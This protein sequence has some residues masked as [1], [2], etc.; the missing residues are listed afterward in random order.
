MTRFQIA[1]IASIAMSALA[2]VVSWLPTVTVP[3][4]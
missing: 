1:Q 3:L 4:A 2:V